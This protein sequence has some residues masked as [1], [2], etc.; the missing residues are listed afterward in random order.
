[1]RRYRNGAAVDL[2][3]AIAGVR[4]SLEVPTSLMGGESYSFNINE[5]IALLEFAEAAKQARS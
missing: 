2:D 5:I 3:S 1:M 4:K